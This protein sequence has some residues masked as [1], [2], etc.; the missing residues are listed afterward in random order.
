MPE[1]RPVEATEEAL[2]AG[3]CG[4]AGAFPDGT[5]GVGAE[6]AARVEDR[7]GGGLGSPED[8]EERGWKGVRAVY[9]FAGC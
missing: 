1:V 3:A 8:A 6:G 7:K 5:E 2:A 9:L 4:G